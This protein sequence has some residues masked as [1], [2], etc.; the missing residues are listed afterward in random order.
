MTAILNWYRMK[1]CHGRDNVSAYPSGTYRKRIEAGCSTMPERKGRQTAA[2]GRV[3]REER[4]ASSFFGGG[5]RGEEDGTS[6][7]NESIDHHADQYVHRV[8]GLDW[9]EYH[10]SF[11]PFS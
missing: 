3:F 5:K 8:R 9:P 10:D 1:P 6:G 4:R 11:D 2:E 7:D